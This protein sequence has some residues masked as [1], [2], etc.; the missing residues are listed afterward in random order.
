VYHT[1][2]HH[3]K[4]CPIR[5]ITF[6]SVDVWTIPIVRVEISVWYLSNSYFGL[7]WDDGCP[8]LVET[9]AREVEWKWRE[10]HND[11]E[12]ASWAQEAPDGWGNTPPV[13]PI[14]D[15]WPHVQPEDQ[16]FPV[17]DDLLLCPNGWLDLLLP[18]SDSIH[19]TVEIRSIV[20]EAEGHS[21]CRLLVPLGYLSVLDLL[22][23]LCHS[24]IGTSLGS[25]TPCHS[26][27]RVDLFGVHE[28]WCFGCCH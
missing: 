27:G 14:V 17:S 23:F 12:V 28:W 3:V 15:S 6:C 20:K 18:T 22:S 4:Q 21:T 5:D 24:T 16:C 10:E 25:C 8:G 26:S 11:A 2:P 9:L 7:G 13:S 19:I 1:A